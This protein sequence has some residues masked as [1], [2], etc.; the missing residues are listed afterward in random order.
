[1]LGHGYGLALKV[2]E[3]STDLEDA[4]NLQELK[5]TPLGNKTLS[6]TTHPHECGTGLIPRASRK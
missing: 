3:L 6:P 2:E 5:N 1:M 4:S